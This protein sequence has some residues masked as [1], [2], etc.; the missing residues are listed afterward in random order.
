MSDEPLEQAPNI[1]EEIARQVGGKITEMG[2][3]LSDG[4]GFAIIS[5]PLPKTHWIY[6]GDRQESYGTFNVPPMPLRMGADWRVI[7][8]MKTPL[9]KRP[10]IAEL[11]EILARRGAEAS[12][13]EILPD[14]QVVVGAIGMSKQEFADKIRAAGRYAVRCATMN[15]KEMDFDPDA[16]VQN[17]ITGMLGYHTNTGLSEDAWDNPTIQ[18]KGEPK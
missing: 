8:Q 12:S 2:G 9:Q 1:V 15:G 17:L 11:E 18:E 10:T 5:M 6:Q 16:L 3:P 13:V 14:G 7:I 4:S